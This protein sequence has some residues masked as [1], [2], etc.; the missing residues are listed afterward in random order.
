MKKEKKVKRK[1]AKKQVEITTGTLKMSV[2]KGKKKENLEAKF[3]PPERN[4]LICPN[5]LL[6]R[7]FW[8]KANVFDE[9]PGMFG[10][11]KVR[12]IGRWTICIACRMVAEYDGEE[13]I[14]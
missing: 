8:V 1:T 13:V 9:R 11:K 3:V 4:P 12:I 6:G 14:K 10:S 7:H 5:T 2:R